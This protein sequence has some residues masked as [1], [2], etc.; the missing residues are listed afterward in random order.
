[1][2]APELLPRCPA[3]DGST[4]RIVPAYTEAG[5]FCEANCVT[6]TDGERTAV[7]V[8]AVASR[9]REPTGL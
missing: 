5:Q 7:Y 2:P 3:L 1:M 9:C 4:L 6:V 8:P